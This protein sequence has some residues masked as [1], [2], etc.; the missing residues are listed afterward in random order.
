MS[1][2][3]PYTDPNAPTPVPAHPN[4]RASEKPEAVEQP[5]NPTARGQIRTVIDTTQEKK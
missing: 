1:K 2:R 5:V 4:T 3:E